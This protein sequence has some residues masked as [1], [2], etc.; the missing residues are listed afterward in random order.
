MRQWLTDRIRAFFLAAAVIIVA[1]GWLLFLGALIVGG[2]LLALVREGRHALRRAPGET[3]GPA[4]GGHS[5][6]TLPVAERNEK[7]ASGAAQARQRPILR[8]V[9]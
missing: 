1:V 5:Q 4:L 8:V 9:Q 2:I 6:T 3:V 7:P